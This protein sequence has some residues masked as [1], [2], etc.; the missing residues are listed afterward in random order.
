[1][2]IFIKTIK[3]ILFLSLFICLFSLLAGCQPASNEKKIGIILPLEN[4]SLDEIVA[5][6]TET[7][8]HESP[9]PVKF[10]V[11]NAQGDLN[12]QRAI[13]Q[14]MKTENYD[15]IVPIGDSKLDAKEEYNS[16]RLFPSAAAPQVE[17]EMRGQDLSRPLLLT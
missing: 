10:K 12:I 16:S 11:A 1:M 8:R 3:I 17:I 4:K 5:G 2:K 6:F 9:I 14:Q 7:V 15:V 13:I